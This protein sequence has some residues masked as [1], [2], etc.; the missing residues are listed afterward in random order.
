MATGQSTKSDK[1]GM[2]STYFFTLCA[3]SNTFFNVGRPFFFR[4]GTYLTNF[5][6]SHNK[7]N[8]PF[9]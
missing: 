6:E 2:E 3:N 7:F 1:L 4:G 8:N 9:K 5:E